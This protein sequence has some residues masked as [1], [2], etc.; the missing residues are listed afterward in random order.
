MAAARLTAKEEN[1]CLA[2][3]RGA[4]SSDA[5]RS[6]YGAAKQKPTTINRNAKR[7]MDKTKI[8]AR[9]D[10]LR[11][12]ILEKIELTA[13]RTL[14]EIGKIAFSN[15]REVFDENGRL[16]PI[17]MMSEAATASISS[18]KVSTK[19]VPGSD[20]VEVEH[21]SE[22]RF[23]DKNSSLE[24]LGKH[25]KLFNEVGSKD[26]PLTLS[27]MSDSMLEAIAAGKVGK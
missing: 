10:E 7:L 17:H 15:I 24:K 18:I 3:L 27:T 13:E 4:N 9:I 23:W 22:L 26:N 19:A 8:R 1:F 20:P 21:I 14:Q 11:A 12:P 5:Y 2:I 16:L 6:A 25:L